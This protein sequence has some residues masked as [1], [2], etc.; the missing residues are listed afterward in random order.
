MTGIN[1]NQGSRYSLTHDS[2]CLVKQTITVD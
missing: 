2:T 1:D